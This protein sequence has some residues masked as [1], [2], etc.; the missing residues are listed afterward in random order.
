M[1]ITTLDIRQFRC[2]E[3]FSCS[4]TTPITLFEGANGTGKTALLEA[5]AYACYLRSFRTSTPRD[6]VRWG[7][8]GFVIRLEGSETSDG[9]ELWDLKVLVSGNKRVVRLNNSPVTSFRELFS[10]YKSIAITGDDLA[11]VTGFPEQR[12]L[13]LDQVLVLADSGYSTL[14]RT[15]RSILRQRNALLA[16]PGSDTASY[17]IWTEKLLAAATAIRSARSMYLTL[18]EEK[19]S[20]L[21]ASLPT[22]GLDKSISFSYKATDYTPELREKERLYKRSLFGA[23]LDDVVISWSNRQ[24]RS[25]ASRGQQKLIVLLTKLAQIQVLQ[26]PVVLL[27]DDF[28]TD[29]DAVMLAELIGLI[30]QQNIQTIITAPSGNPLRKALEHTPHAILSLS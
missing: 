27:I 11:V 3:H 12:R 9:A 8:D 1:L 16:H 30:A 29:F 28:A 7:S 22:K 17:D 15:Y 23:H 21:L 18:L 5:L 14:L 20:S 4:F 25:Y 10:V 26:K 19:V 2:F 6:L 24:S 13:F